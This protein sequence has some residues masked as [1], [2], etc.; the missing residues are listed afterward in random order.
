MELVD[1]DASL[2][3]PVIRLPQLTYGGSA[4]VTATA[5]QTAKLPCN[6]QDLGDRAVSWIRKRDL[7][8]LT[9]DIFT[10]TSD[11]RYQV[12]HPEGSQNWTLLV[13][14]AQARDTGVYECQ[15]NT[16]PK[17]SLA[18]YL[19]V[20]AVAL[21]WLQNGEPLAA[22]RWVTETSQ[23]YVTSRLTISGARLRDSGAYT[24]APAN[25]AHAHVQVHVISGEH[26]AAMQHGAAPVQHCVTP[27]H[28]IVT[29]LCFVVIVHCR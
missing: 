14:Y 28:L 4:N 27:H 10:Y 11:A 17:R 20:V 22:D 13:K 8:I 2:A 16:E 12:A 15:V 21:S 23:E 3:G 25:A 6:I 9:T 19:R 24:C 18:F 1:R 7:H 5:G 26:P 29:L